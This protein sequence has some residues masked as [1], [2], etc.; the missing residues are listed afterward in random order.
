VEL[1]DTTLVI[2]PF[3][4]LTREQRHGVT[5]EGERL[6]KTMHPQSSYD[7]RFGTVRRQSPA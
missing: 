5:E 4:G 2:E 6:L 3:G 7:I 1:E